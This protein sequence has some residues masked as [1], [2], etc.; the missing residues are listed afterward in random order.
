M[1][2][3]LR[4]RKAQP[5]LAHELQGENGKVWSTWA[6]GRTPRDGHV[7]AFI[8]VQDLKFSITQSFVL[9]A[10]GHQCQFSTITNE[11]VSQP[12]LSKVKPVQLELELE[13]THSLGPL[14][15]TNVCQ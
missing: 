1:P 10:T 6:H 3:K 12:L 4:L 15:P 14:K 7:P 13:P 5:D 2:A 8:M 9:S 11:S